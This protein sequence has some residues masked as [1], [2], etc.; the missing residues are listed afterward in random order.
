MIQLPALDGAAARLE[1]SSCRVVL[2]CAVFTLTLFLAGCGSS[3]FAGR[4][5]VYPPDLDF[6]DPEVERRIECTWSSST[7]LTDESSKRV[8]VRI[9]DG[10]GDQLLV[11]QFDVRAAALAVDAVWVSSDEFTLYLT[12]RA[13]RE[14]PVESRHH[15]ATARYVFNDRLRRFER[16]SIEGARSRAR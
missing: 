13:D 6:E 9:T 1:R 4:W 8:L 12:P 16:V 15:V 7:P 5:M 3:N 14:L 11:D 2:V 10:D